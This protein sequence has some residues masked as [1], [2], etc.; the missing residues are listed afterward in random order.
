MTLA[1][2]VALPELALVASTTRVSSHDPVTGAWKAVRDDR[3][4]EFSNV[5]RVGGGPARGGWAT[6]GGADVYWQRAVY[7]ELERHP[8]DDVPALAGV[9]RDVT[10]RHAAAL[11]GV[12]YTPPGEQ[13][14]ERW[15][16]G[17][18]LVFPTMYG[19]RRA[20]IF[21]HG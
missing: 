11:G 6:G 19:F 9:V 10:E 4:G 2:S 7:D 16:G 8:A 5:R 21:G 15:P 18:H 1:I 17:V 13:N 12:R 20:T 14:P 3:L